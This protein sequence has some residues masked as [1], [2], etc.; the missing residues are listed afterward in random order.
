MDFEH[1]GFRVSTHV[2]PDEA[3]V[4]WLC[5]ADIERADGDSLKG[6]PE[7]LELTIPRLKIDP[8]MAVS[9]LEHQ[10]KSAIDDWCR[11]LKN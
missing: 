7:G 8:L 3:G 5:R 9:A 6:A 4:Q 2:V 1:C 10:A 11:Q